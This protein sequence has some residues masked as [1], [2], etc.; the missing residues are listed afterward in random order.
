MVDIIKGIIKIFKFLRTRIKKSHLVLFISGIV[1]ILSGVLSWKYYFSNYYLFSKNEDLFLETVERYFEYHS[2]YLPKNGN[3]KTVTL[4]E[5]YKD[6]RI[7]VLN[8]PNKNISCSEDSWVKVYNDNGK[9]VY[10][11]YLKC[12]KYESNV[13]HEGPEIELNGDSTVYVSLNKEYQE[14]GVKSVK[15]NKDGNIDVKKVTIDNDVN[16]KKVGN[17]SVTYT[18]KDKLNNVTK[19]TRKV[20]VA[21]NLTD[22]VKD[23][24]DESNYYKG[25]VNNNYLLFSGMMFRIINVNDDGTVRLISN[26]IL[27]NLRTNYD[28][29]EDSN[30]DKYLNTEYLNIIYDKSYL[31]DTELCTGNI[32][33]L[34]DTSNNCSSK[35][36]RKVGILDIESFNKSFLNNSSYLCSNY[37]YLFSNKIDNN[38][39]NSSSSST[40]CL[41]SV[42]KDTLSSIKPVITLKSNLI[43]LSGNGTYKNPYKLDDYSY[44]K[45]QD[46]I[47][48]RLSGEYINYSGNIY[49]I[50]D[51]D[52]NK[53][54]TVISIGPISKNINSLVNR[55]YLLAVLSKGKK[56]IFN[57]EDENNAGYLLNNDYIDYINDSYIIKSN[58]KIPLNEE[59]K[60]YNEYSNKNI[61]VK[62]SLPKTYDLFAGKQMENANYMYEYVYI[63]ESQNENNVFYVDLRNGRVYDGIKNTDEY[64]MKIVMTLKGDL[65]IKSGKGT[66]NSPYYIR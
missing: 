5:L 11:T 57:L 37:G 59:T 14:L 8:I 51:V 58:Y 7:E 22:T 41:T 18:V 63:D 9:Y 64:T 28:K 30:V 3:V 47:N 62:L 1:L 39:V 53:N 56:F 45:Q 65:S 23:N 25:S 42:S 49:R 31:V 33:D 15:D 19:V 52:K 48:T 32:N 35:I 54:V 20:I 60:V 17:Y 44:G 2:I 34:S 61:S 43:I 6:S 21:R 13:D 46:K 40:N 26:E 55:E 66:V 29:Y 27:N 38:I 16:T 10:H 50:M 36:K 4:E 24:T 12:G